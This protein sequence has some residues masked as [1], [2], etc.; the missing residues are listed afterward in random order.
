[1]QKN[2]NETVRAIFVGWLL[3]F[4]YDFGATDR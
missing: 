1:M 3:V 4:D 2:E